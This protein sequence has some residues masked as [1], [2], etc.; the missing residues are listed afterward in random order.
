TGATLIDH[1][2]SKERPKDQPKQTT[3]NSR[4]GQRPEGQR[5]TKPQTQQ[6]TAQIPD[7]QKK[8]REDPSQPGRQKKPRQKHQIQRTLRNCSLAEGQTPIGEPIMAKGQMRSN[9]EVKKPKQ[10]KKPTPA[11]TPSGAPPIRVAPSSS[12]AQKKN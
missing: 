9:R 12:A 6:G 7:Q 1:E 5:Q 3:N 8:R 10:A 11:T 2:Q 4:K